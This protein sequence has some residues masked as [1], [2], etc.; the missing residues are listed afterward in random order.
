MDLADVDVLG[1]Q[2]EVEFAEDGL[3]QAVAGQ[4]TTGGAG[5]IYAE[6]PADEP[7][8]GWLI[9]KGNGSGPQANELTNADPFSD[10]DAEL[11]FAKVTFTNGVMALVRA[12]NVFD[13]RGCEIVAADVSGKNNGIRLNG[14]TLLW[15]EG[16]GFVAEVACRLECVTAPGISS[17]KIVVKPC[18]NLLINA[19]WSWAGDVVL[20]NHATLSF[21]C[22][23]RIKSLTVND[24]T[25]RVFLN[26]HVLKIA[27]PKPKNWTMPSYVVPG[28]DADGNPGRIKW[29]K[30]IL[31]YVR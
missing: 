12:G 31:F 15:P 4:N 11:R 21:A 24:T 20:S 9:L 8:H 1:L 13:L 10:L 23:Y 16:E 26:G 18:G 17:K 25:A 3:A 7:G 19:A 27:K 6:T 29:V 2:R 14:G 5:T 28:A 30:G 22:D